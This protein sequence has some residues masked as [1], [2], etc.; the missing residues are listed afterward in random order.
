M[1]LSLTRTDDAYQFTSVSENDHM[2]MCDASEEIGGQNTAMRPMEVLL[3]SLAS[4]SAIDIV[5]ILNK[6]KQ[7]IEQFEIKI[8]GIRTG[9][10]PSPFKKIDLL[11][12]V[13]GQ[14]DEKKLSKAIQLTQEKY[15]SVKFSL[16]PDIDISYDY[17]IIGS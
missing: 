3:H 16:H 11:V 1:K 6:Q 10:V 14:I 9:G 13:S 7:V 12:T 8:E 17:K 15:C 2:I 5:N 4:C